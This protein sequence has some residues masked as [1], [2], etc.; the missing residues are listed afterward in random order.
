MDV[1]AS[2]SRIIE[3]SNFKEDIA[4]SQNA[5]NKNIFSPGM[6]YGAFKDIGKDAVKQTDRSSDVDTLKGNSKRKPS[7]Y[8]VWMK[9]N[10]KNSETSAGA[11]HVL[12]TEQFDKL[13]NNMHQS[14]RY[15]Q[16]TTAIKQNEG[17]AAELGGYEFKP[18]MNKHSLS[19][20]TNMKKIQDRLGDMLKEK[21]DYLERKRKEQNEAA[22][23]SFK[24]AREGA[25]MSDKYL[26]KMGRVE[27]STP[28][29]FFQYH[30]E[31]LRRNE[32]RKQIYDELQSKDLTFKP[33]INAGSIKLQDK[34]KQNNSLIIDPVT[35]TT[36][37]SS[38]D[39]LRKQEQESSLYAGNPLV[40][41]SEHP[42]KANCHDYTQVCIP[43]AVSYSIVFDSQTSTENIYDYVKFYRDDTH[44]VFWGC[45]KYCGGY[46]NSSSNWPGV[47][48]RPPL[49]INNSKFVIYFKTNNSINDWGFKMTITPT[50][51]SVILA[52]G[53][54]KVNPNISNHA[55]RMVSDG[56][57][58]ERLYKNGVEKINEITTSYSEAVNSK[59]NISME[60]KADIAAPRSTTKDKSYVSQTKTL[61]V[62][63]ELL[64]DPL[65]QYP[66][67]VVEYSDE[68]SS[69][70]KN[71]KFCFKLSEDEIESS[72]YDL[73]ESKRIN[74]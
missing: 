73:L 43:G 15:K 70:L 65:H 72:A 28:D 7:P 62:Q 53:S 59:L 74:I 2:L 13:V 68:H 38:I 58:H 55:K 57:V 36:V 60:S 6:G 33:H 12:S 49:I 35:R 8:D 4:F 41:E 16:T 71:L 42:Y 5:V 3:N 23:P 56:N 48:G 69:M 10:K 67:T 54:D 34:L 31:K 19:L 25:S 21:Q 9:N 64:W 24:P 39:K 45:G 32:V 14:N 11:N 46:D 20:P 40:I 30:Q 63:D 18:R 61:L 1:F 52:T 17:L 37:V 47:N 66:V 26:K 44:T 50:L 51:S 22:K 29:D 27:K